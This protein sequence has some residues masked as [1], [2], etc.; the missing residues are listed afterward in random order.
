MGYPHSVQVAPSRTRIST[1]HPV[2]S[3]TL[4]PGLR[5][6][7]RARGPRIFPDS[8]EPTRLR[9]LTRSRLLCLV[10]AEVGEQGQGHVIELLGVEGGDGKMVAPGHGLGVEEH[11][12]ATGVLLGTPLEECLNV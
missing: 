7:G 10:R 8:L 1:R 11:G 5:I 9:P 6:Y 4:Y 3:N 12:P 2:T